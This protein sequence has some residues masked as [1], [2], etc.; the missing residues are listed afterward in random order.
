[1]GQASLGS[2]QDGLK[3]LSDHTLRLLWVVE[4]MV[5]KAII[6]LVLLLLILLFAIKIL[7]RT[8]KMFIIHLILSNKRFIYHMFIKLSNHR[9]LF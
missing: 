8:F 5:L 4:N 2:L 6:F 7:S 3:G 1:M 9:Q